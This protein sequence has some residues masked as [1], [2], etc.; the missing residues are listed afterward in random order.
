MYGRVNNTNKLFSLLLICLTAAMLAGCGASPPKKII[1]NYFYDGIC[2]SCN[3]IQE[4][5]DEFSAA[6]DGVL[7]LYPY[8]VVTC[9]VMTLDGA[10]QEADFFGKL[11]MDEKAIRSLSPPLLVVG[12]KILSGD[13]DIRQNLREAFLA[14][15]E[16]LSAQH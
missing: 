10:K 11:G 8:S 15:G 12:G 7:D 13:D 5:N 14:A 3:Y 2:G 16:N 6:L 4:F 9:N 1:I